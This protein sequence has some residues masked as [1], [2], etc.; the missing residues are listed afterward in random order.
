[1]MKDGVVQQIDTPQRVYGEPANLHVAR[2][3]GYRNVFPMT[4]E[5]E[6]GNRVALSGPDFPLTGTRML[7][8]T[9]G[10]AMVAIRPDDLVVGPAPNGLNAI[11]AE[12]ELVEY[13]G[14]ESL[15]DLVTR[16]G[17][18]LIVRTAVPVV[19][20]ASLQVHAPV[21]RTLVYPTE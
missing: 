2:F 20:G 7:P 5:R 4:I 21:E 15:V 12:V 16:S 19:V 11:T 14:R 3:M 17:M 13:A 6:E 8:L 10:K 18:R 1:V 9:D